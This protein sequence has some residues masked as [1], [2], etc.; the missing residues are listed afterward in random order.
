[1]SAICRVYIDGTMENLRPRYILAVGLFQKK[2]QAAAK[3]DIDLA[4][5]RFS[6]LTTVKK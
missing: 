1:M 3:Q 6:D 4:K 5:L 2:T